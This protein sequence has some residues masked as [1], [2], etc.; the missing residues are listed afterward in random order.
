[1]PINLLAVKLAA[2]KIPYQKDV[3]SGS[4]STVVR[5]LKIKEAKW[6]AG[7]NYV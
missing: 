2:E 7:Q 4:D 3:L 6:Q 1:M 5:D